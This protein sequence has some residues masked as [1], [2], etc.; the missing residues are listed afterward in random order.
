[1]SDRLLR[2]RPPVLLQADIP[3]ATA[4]RDAKLAHNNEF[5]QVSSPL[6]SSGAST[7]HHIPMPKRQGPKW[8][9][10]QI[11]NVVASFPKTKLQAPKRKTVGQVITRPKGSDA[12]D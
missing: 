1:M 10:A 9:P 2:R 7:S 11:V 5:G 6:S 4:Q 3:R 8:K 12:A